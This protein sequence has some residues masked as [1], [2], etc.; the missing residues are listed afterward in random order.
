MMVGVKAVL[1][2]SELSHSR[3]LMITN[4]LG[5]HVRP[6]QRFAELAQAFRGEVHVGVEDREASGKSIMSLM[7]LRAVH[8]SVMRISACGE[9]ARQALDVLSF[10]VQNDFFVEDGASGVLPADRHVGRLVGIASCFRSD[11][12][13]EVAGRLADARSFA[14]VDGVGLTPKSRVSFHIDGEDAEQARRVLEKL[15]QR[16]FYVDEESGS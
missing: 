5:F 3:D 8:G 10:L 6:I 15:L 1:M 12:R 14:D 11:V 2:C 9:D 16:R 4:P 7:S 13:V